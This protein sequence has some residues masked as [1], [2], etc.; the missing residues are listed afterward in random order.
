M[1]DVYGEYAPSSLILEIP[2]FTYNKRRIGR[3]KRPFHAKKT[4]LDLSSGFDKT[5]T[6]ISH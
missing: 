2:E 6:A 5:L 4:Q 3:R 1:T